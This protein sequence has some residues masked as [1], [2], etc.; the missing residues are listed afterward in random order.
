MI[1]DIDYTEQGFTDPV[2][3]QVYA[4]I[5][6][7]AQMSYVALDKKNKVCIVEFSKINKDSYDTDKVIIEFTG[8]ALRAF[9]DETTVGGQRIGRQFFLKLWQELV[10]NQENVKRLVLSRDLPSGVSFVTPAFTPVLVG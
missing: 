10:K 7:R 9:L 4:P 3:Q 5:N 6:W 8:P 1:Y 2:T